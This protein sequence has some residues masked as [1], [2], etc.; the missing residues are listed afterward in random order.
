MSINIIVMLY[1]QVFI[2]IPLQFLLLK[3]R[4]TSYLSVSQPLAVFGKWRVFH[5]HKLVN[6]YIR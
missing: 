3:S 1:Y 5:N 6:E 2:F 4:A